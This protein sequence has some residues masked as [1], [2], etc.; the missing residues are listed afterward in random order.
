MLPC[1]LFFPT[2]NIMCFKAAILDFSAVVQEEK[3]KRNYFWLYANID[4]VI[5]IE[6]Y[7]DEE[8]T[9]YDGTDVTSVCDDSAKPS[10]EHPE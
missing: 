6:P 7:A 1:G 3:M 5:D 4:D 9:S 10:P 2:L 8:D